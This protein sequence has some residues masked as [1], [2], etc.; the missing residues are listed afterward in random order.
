MA[1]QTYDKQMINDIADQYEDRVKALRDAA[2][3]LDEDTIRINQ[4]LSENSALSKSLKFAM[5]FTAD[6]TT[7]VGNLKLQKLNQSS[8]PNRT[9]DAK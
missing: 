6:V 4:S 8:E 7:A 1:W 3:A 5:A 2:A 9:K